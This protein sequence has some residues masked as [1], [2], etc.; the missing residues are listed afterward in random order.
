M[1]SQPISA[2]IPDPLLAELSSSSSSLAASQHIDVSWQN[3]GENE[4]PASP[5]NPEQGCSVTLPNPSVGC[6]PHFLSHP[7]LPILG[8][9]DIFTKAKPPCQFPITSLVERRSS[10]S[11]ES[12]RGG[13]GV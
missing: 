5:L 3:K 7:I 8:G 1:V 12:R 4:H 11:K 2:K 6:F 10:T 13:C 9:M